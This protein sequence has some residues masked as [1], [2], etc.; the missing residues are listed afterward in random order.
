MLVS[1]TPDEPL[2]IR[3]QC[4]QPQ[5]NTWATGFGLGGKAAS[6][7]NAAALDYSMG[8][9][10]VG[11]ETMSDTHLLGFYGGYLDNYV[12]TGADESAKING[13]TFGSYYVGRDDNQYYIAASGFEFDGYESRRRIAFANDTAFGDTNAW[14]GYSYFERGASSATDFWRC[15]LS[16]APSTSISVKTAS[17]RRALRRPISTC[18]GSTP[19]RS[20][21]LWAHGSTERATRR[22]AG[23]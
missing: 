3:D 16:S 8:G 1:S 7:G 6:D 18:R 22:V 13:G 21:A 5:W 19:I 23:Q 12:S 2:I 11:M 9:T 20:A 10:L 14:K 15:S 17:R 4:C